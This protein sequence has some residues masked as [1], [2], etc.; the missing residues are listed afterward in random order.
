MK[1]RDQH[2]TAFSTPNGLFEFK[3]MPFGL[4]NAPATF[5]RLMDLVLAGLQWSSCLVYLDDIII[6]GKDFK[7]HLENL[8]L[9]L[10][11]IKDAGLRLNTTKCAFFQDRV[12]YLGHVVS[13]DG[14]SV[15]QLKVNKVKNWPV[16]KTSKE[17]QQFL[18]LA[19]YY[20]RFVQGFANTARPLHRLT[21]KRQSSP[22][23][24]NVRQL[25]MN[26]ATDCVIPQFS[27]F[28]ITQN[29]SSSIQMQVILDLVP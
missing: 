12:N 1:K 7:S 20:R 16:P 9:V 18:G 29:L 26:S 11:R 4:C 19:N 13:R 10:Q 17:V 15:D 3:V 8:S 21:K 28:L 14:V 23:L 24:L 2:R 5:Q 22:G 6:L 27:H 25:L